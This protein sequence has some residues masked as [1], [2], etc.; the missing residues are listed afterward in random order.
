MIPWSRGK[1][2]SNSLV[3]VTL[4]ALCVG[5]FQAEEPRGGGAIQPPVELFGGDAGPSNDGSIVDDG[6]FVDVDAGPDLCSP[7]KVMDLSTLTSP[8]GGRYAPRNI[9][10]IWIERSDGTFVKTLEKWART[11]QRYLTNFRRRTGGDTTDAITGATLSSHRT[12]AERWDLRDLSGCAIAPGDYVVVLEL[13]D[14]NSTGAL[15]TVP[16]SWDGGDLELSPPDQRCFGSMHLSIH[17]P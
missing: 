1:S 9:G 16:F 12:H 3:A 8:Y 13:T 17:D 7:N 15:A 14:T 6:G 11:R 5:C 10:A 2:I 4:G